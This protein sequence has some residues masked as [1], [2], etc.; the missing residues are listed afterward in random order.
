VDLPPISAGTALSQ[1]VDKSRMD[2]LLGPGME[3][4]EEAMPGTRPGLQDYLAKP[5]DPNNLITTVLELAR[6]RIK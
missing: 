1:D 6:E 4:K 5:V 3:A 2:A